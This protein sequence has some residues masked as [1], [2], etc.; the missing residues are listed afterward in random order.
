MSFNT[1]PSMYVIQSFNTLPSTYVIQSFNTLPSTY[2]I[3]SFD[4]LPSTYVIQ[5]FNTL[6]STYVIQSFNILPSTYVIQ[7][8][9]TLPST[10]VIQSRNTL[11]SVCVDCVSLLL[12][13]SMSV[14]CSPTCVSM[15]AVVTP[16]AASCAPATR[17]S[18]SQTMARTALVCISITCYLETFTKCHVSRLKTCS[19]LLQN[20]KK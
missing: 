18:L 1:L 9:N 3:Q 13:T 15:V 8:F 7:S 2:V 5:S 14:C 16:S 4:T 20:I 19:K 6:P 10:Y 12:Q 17:A 11:P